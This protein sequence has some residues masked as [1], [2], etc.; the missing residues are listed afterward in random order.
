[1]NEN[2]KQKY[3]F[4]EKIRVTQSPMP[5]NMPSNVSPFVKRDDY[6][7]PPKEDKTNQGKKKNCTI[8]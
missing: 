7:E 6:K 3:Y 4:D 2:W 1:M 8:S 5:N